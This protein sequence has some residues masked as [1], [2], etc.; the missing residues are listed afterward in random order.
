MERFGWMICLLASLIAPTGCN[1]TSKE[2]DS[3]TADGGKPDSDATPG[4][5]EGPDKAVFAFL[6]AVRTG[7]DVKADEMLTE[8]AREAIAEEKMEVAPPGSETASFEVK[9]V[10][11]ISPE[12]SESDDEIAHVASTWTD[13]GDDGEPRTDEIIWVLKEG[14]DGWRIAGM[15][16]KVFD[17][18]PPVILD[19]EDP[20]DM[21]RKQEEI[22]KEMERRARKEAEEFL[23]N[24]DK[25]DQEDDQPDDSV[26]AVA[27]EE[28]D[29]EPAREVRHAQSKGNSK[30][31]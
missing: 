8:L 11:M 17:D 20:K 24:Q 3:V 23:A 14:N 1:N 2:T 21:Q 7:D 18:L 29:P 30:R 12:E 4:D 13:I 26:E 5:S 25:A 10:E 28:P 9:E 27:D 22:D 31:K 16:T 6:E 19:F 15:A